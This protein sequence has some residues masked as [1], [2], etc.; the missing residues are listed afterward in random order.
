MKKVINYIIVFVLVISAFVSGL[1][2]AKAEGEVEIQEQPTEQ[3]KE[4][5]ITLD[6]NGGSLEVTTLKIKTGEKYTNLPIP[7]RDKYKFVG[8]FTKKDGSFNARYY[9]NM[10][11]ELKTTVGQDNDKLKEHWYAYGRDEGKICSQYNVNNGIEFKET[12]DITLYAIWEHANF[13]VTFDAM[14]GTVTPSSISIN[15]GEK[16]ANLPVPT[17]KGY[18]FSGWYKNSTDMFN[19]TWYANNNSDVK[20][21]VGTR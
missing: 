4:Y 5:T 18:Q 15:T 7:T 20:E 19:A 12:N 9:A 3:V 2:I 1:T 21:K 8:W 17:K 6:A 16:Y 14:G 11:K 10:Y 13:T